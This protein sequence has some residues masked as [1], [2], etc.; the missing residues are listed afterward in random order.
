MDA[1]QLVDFAARY[2]AAWCSQ[3]SERVAAF[4]STS[5]ALTINGG[6]PAVGRS[7]I[8]EVV[9][10]F[11]TAF[12]DLVLTMDGVRVE[13]D[14]AVYQWTFAGKNIGPAG[15]GQ[16]VLFSGFEEWAIGADGL[17][18]GSLGHFDEADYRHQREHGTSAAQ[19]PAGGSGPV[20]NPSR[21]HEQTGSAV[22]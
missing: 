14:R 5:G 1:E 4:F 12:P 2:T 3:Q 19:R 22:D 17:I 13:G 15:T 18:A 11:M 7:A 6:A 16:Q 9:Q 20:K 21:A 8:R 10:G